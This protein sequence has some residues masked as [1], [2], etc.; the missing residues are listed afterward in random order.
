MNT[1]YYTPGAATMAKAFLT[2]RF[3]GGGEYFNRAVSIL[4]H[5]RHVGNGRITLLTSAPLVLVLDDSYQTLD[6]TV[7]RVFQPHFTNRELDS[8]KV[9]WMGAHL[10][11][12]PKRKGLRLSNDN[13]SAALQRIAQNWAL[14]N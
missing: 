14:T 6:D 13:I 7:R 3:L 2:D 5:V 9:T 11:H 8:L 1:R 10:V 4:T 12:L